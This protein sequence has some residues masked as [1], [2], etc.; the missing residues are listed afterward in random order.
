MSW[1]GPQGVATV[2]CSI[3]VHGAT[4]VSGAEWISLRE[5]QVRDAPG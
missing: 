3:I 1:F 5:G 2:F 4:D